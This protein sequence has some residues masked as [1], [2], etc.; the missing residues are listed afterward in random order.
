M[1]N[2]DE[3]FHIAAHQSGNLQ[4][5]PRP[6]RSEIFAGSWGN[7]RISVQI[8]DYGWNAGEKYLPQPGRI[9]P[10]LRILNEGMLRVG[11]H[12]IFTFGRGTQN[13]RASGVV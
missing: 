5:L 7:P 11:R 9:L 2:A 8:F 10:G 3:S 4:Q 12:E 13:E 6:L 1:A